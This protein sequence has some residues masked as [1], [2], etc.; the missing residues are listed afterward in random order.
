MTAVRG[1]DDV[2]A[3]DI[4]TKLI[5][6][7]K[8]LVGSE[9]I[10]S[11]FQYSRDI[12][13]SISKPHALCPICLCN[14]TEHDEYDDDD[15]NELSVRIGETMWM[16]NTNDNTWCKLPCFH[17]FHYECFASYVHS[18][19][20][21][22]EKRRQNSLLYG[23]NLPDNVISELRDSV[24]EVVPCPHCRER[25]MLTDVVLGCNR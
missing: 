22:Y 17:F 20:D 9:M 25:A 18:Q 10:F 14:I 7:A 12:L 11:L 23:H 1:L 21:L 15:Q 24:D 19:W 6:R 5:E 3:H 2:Q 4:L 16:T 13:T 8:T